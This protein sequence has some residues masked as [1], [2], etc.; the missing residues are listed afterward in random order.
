IGGLI[1]S[2]NSSAT[3]AN[4]YWATDASGR[5][6]SAGGGGATLAQLQCPVAATNISC[7]TSGLYDG[8]DG[9]VD[10]EGNPYWFF[11]DAS[12]LPGLSLG[13]EIYR[14]TDGDGVLD[15]DD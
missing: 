2:A 15:F 10:S 8:W 11:G 6:Q 3:V 13:G 9:Y 5:T 1:G 4:S 7:L 14:D 12:T